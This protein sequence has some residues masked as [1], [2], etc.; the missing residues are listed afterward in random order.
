M[1]PSVSQHTPLDT[2][3]RLELRRYLQS[4][5]SEWRDLDDPG[6]FADS[7]D[8]QLIEA[9]VWGLEMWGR[10]PLARAA[11]AALDGALSLWEDADERTDE[12][13][14]AAQKG[15]VPS[16][17]LIREAVDSW[18]GAPSVAAAVAADAL[19]A[20]MPDLDLTRPELSYLAQE[21]SCW[22]LLSA[23]ECA[24]TTNHPDPRPFAGRAAV[25][26]ARA[27]ITAAR[28]GGA[29]EIHAHI[30]RGLTLWLDGLE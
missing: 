16:P 29:E 1:E 22:V 20:R 19:L 21:P 26:A 4:D 25:C 6:P 28:P 14:A 23:A 8:L 13:V 17:E 30:R 12:I 11:L 9:W 27:A 7:E 5:G 2:A 24:A 10:E 18:V 3:A 15:D